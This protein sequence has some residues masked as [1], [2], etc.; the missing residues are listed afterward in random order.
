MELKGSFC[1]SAYIS[2]PVTRYCFLYICMYTLRRYLTSI[3]GEVSQDKLFS[4]GS[5]FFKNK[6]GNGTNPG[7]CII[8]P[9]LINLCSH[10][11]I[12]VYL[13]TCSGV[14]EKLSQNIFA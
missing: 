4:Q 7:Q 5:H 9:S 1:C 14:Y 10:I 11:Y 13:H 3:H 6:I 2:V 8:Q 12:C